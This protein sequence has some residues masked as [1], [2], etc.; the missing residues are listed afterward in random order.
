M[1]KQPPAEWEQ[2]DREQRTTQLRD[3][4]LKSWGESALLLRQLGQAGPA[5]SRTTW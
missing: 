1:K 2:L 5:V 4:V 3:A